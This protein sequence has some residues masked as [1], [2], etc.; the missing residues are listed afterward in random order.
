MELPMIRTILAAVLVAWA[1]PAAAQSSNH[2]TA[3]QF[4][5]K[6]TISNIFEI[7]SSKL[8]LQKS[9]NNKVDQFARMIINDH[10]KAGNQL[11]K[12]V[13]KLHGIKMPSKLDSE[14]MRTLSKLRSES[15]AAFNHTYRTVQIDGH[16][17]AVQMFQQYADNGDNSQLKAWAQQTLPVLQ[18]HLKH[19]EALPQLRAPTVGAGASRSHS[20][21]NTQN[22][23]HK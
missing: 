9:K 22:N 21:S 19:A 14:H 15:G 10:T 12:V 4:V 16:Q 20:E 17:K 6:A 5:N 7:R 13:S 1:L 23:M 8:A 2:L 18:K 3:Q 11:K